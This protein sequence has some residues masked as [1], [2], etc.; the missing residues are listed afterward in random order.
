MISSDWTQRSLAVEDWLKSWMF[1]QASGLMALDR[2]REMMAYSLVVP[3]K[4]FRPVLFLTVLEGLGQ[5]LIHGRRT[6][7][8]LE[9]I[10]TYSLIHDDLPSMDDDDVRRGQAS[11]HKR[12]GEAQAILAGDALLTLAFELLGSEP[13]TVAGA[14]VL[15]LAQASGM[16]GMV[17]GQILDMESSGKIPSLEQ[18][19]QIHRKKTGALIA[20]AMSL[21][22]IRAHASPEFVGKL[23]QLGHLFGMIFQIR[24]DILDVI[25]TTESMGKTV[26]KDLEQ[27][28]MTYPSLLGLDGAKE[29]LRTVHKEAWQLIDELGVRPEELKSVLQFLANRQH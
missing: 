23:R 10:H 22:G 8:A 17:A 15:E 14:M 13:S 6:A 27:G 7:L 19:Q 24:D 16:N 11:S 2:C 28:K 20:A 12:F 3:C 18:L 1:S 26:G 29:I 21:A 5:P 25:S 4:R 9:C